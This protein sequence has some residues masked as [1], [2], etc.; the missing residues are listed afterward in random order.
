[1]LEEEKDPE[2]ATARQLMA[3][4]ASGNRVKAL[5]Q[6]FVPALVVHGLADPLLPKAAGMEIAKNIRGAR[7]LGI[8]GMGHD[9]PPA[10]I[11]EIARAVAAHCYGA[12]P[13]FSAK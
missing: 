8:E 13:D 12:G 3:I 9:L 5:R 2:K 4:L 1:M 11:D 10:H 6:L 7:F